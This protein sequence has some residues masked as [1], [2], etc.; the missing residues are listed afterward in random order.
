VFVLARHGDSVLNVERR[1]NGDPSLDVPLTERGREEARRLG[2]QIAN[3]PISLCVV[4]R[5]PRTR[6]TAEEA[7][8]GRD[9]PIEVEPLLDDIDVGELEG[10][11]IDDYRGWKAKHTRADRFPGGESLDEAAL[12]YVRGFRRLLERDEE[13]VL[14]ACH[15][16]PIRYALNAAAAAPDLDGPGHEIANAAPYLFERGALERAAAG[17]EALTPGK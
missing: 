16:I 10:W 4:T 11:S 13:G 7:L 2:L 8:A 3:V 5:F 17:I 9:V 12:R 14:V 6:A 1:I 15:E